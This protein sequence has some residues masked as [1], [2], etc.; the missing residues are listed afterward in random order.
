MK[1]IKAFKS[2]ILGLAMMVFAS[3]LLYKQITNDYLILSG[4]YISGLILVFGSGD[5]L[6]NLLEKK[7]LGKTLF[8]KDDSYN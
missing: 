1:Y 7:I 5:R 3:V 4:L 6:I 8:T 2:T